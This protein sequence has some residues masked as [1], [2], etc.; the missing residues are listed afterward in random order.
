MLILTGY[1]WLVIIVK[2]NELWTLLFKDCVTPSLVVVVV[3]SA[4]TRI[5]PLHASINHSLLLLTDKPRR[6]AKSVQPSSE[7][8]FQSLQT[9]HKML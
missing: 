9:F 8:N 3:L 7:Q 6:V 2:D 1:I 4:C 5:R